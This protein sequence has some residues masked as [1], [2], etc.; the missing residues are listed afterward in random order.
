MKRRGEKRRE[1]MW[2]G[3]LLEGCLSIEG[4]KEGCNIVYYRRL[5]WR[6]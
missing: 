3:K 6:E 5:K 1:E 4:R 2:Y